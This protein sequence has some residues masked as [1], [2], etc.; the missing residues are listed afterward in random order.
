MVF[1]N[2]A[3]ESASSKVG[4]AEELDFLLGFR[5]GRHF[6]YAWRWREGEGVGVSAL[7]WPGTELEVTSR[8]VAR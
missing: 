1:T 5:N 3:T 6:G 2:D 8:A 4:A 7:Q